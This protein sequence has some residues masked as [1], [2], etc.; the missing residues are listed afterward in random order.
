MKQWYC[1]MGGRQYGPI[2]EDV[3]RTWVAEGRVGPADRLWSEGFSGW[4]PAAA[5]APA[6]FVGVAE[7]PPGNSI[8]PCEA[9]GGTGGRTPNAELMASARALLKGRWGLPIGFSLLLLLLQGGSGWVPYVGGLASLILSGPLI[10]G[11][12]VFYLAFT[13]RGP[14]GLDMLFAGFKNFGHA[15]RAYLL[16]VIFVSLW[17]LLFALPGIVLAVIAGLLSEGS[18]AAIGVGIVLCGILAIVAAIYASLRYAMTFYLLADDRRLGSLTAIR[19]SRDMMD[20]Y[21]WKLLCLQVRFIGW[22]LLCILTLGIGFLWLAP[23]MAASYAGFYDDL[24]PRA[25]Q[26]TLPVA[27]SPGAVC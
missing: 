9:V 18:E 1:H 19:N 20:G 25:D 16:V 13:R 6:L 3:L 4:T 27:D 8:V 23:Y 24:R 7:A 26:P 21:K 2:S 11:G 14:A 22:G 15:L 5:A 10:L 17:M 12:M